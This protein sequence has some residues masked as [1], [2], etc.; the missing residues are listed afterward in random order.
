[1]ARRRGIE[2]IPIVSFTLGHK[3]ELAKSSGHEIMNDAALEA[4]RNGASYPHIPEPL[5]EKYKSKWFS[6]SDFIC[7]ILLN[8]SSLFISQ[9]KLFRFLFFKY[10]SQEIS[11]KI[12]KGPEN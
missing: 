11:S 5:N 3:G 10:G 7:K 4:I 1:L 12:N 8:I 9:L 2:G 6:F